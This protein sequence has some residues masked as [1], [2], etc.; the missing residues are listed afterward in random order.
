LTGQHYDKAVLAIDRIMKQYREVA[1]LQEQLAHLARLRDEG[2][3]YWRELSDTL[4]KDPT[5]LWNLASTYK[6]NRY[7]L[8]P[9]FVSQEKAREI[10]QR[11][12]GH[13]AI[14]RDPEKRKWIAEK[15]S[16]PGIPVWL[17]AQR[18]HQGWRWDNGKGFPFAAWAPG[19]PDNHE[20]KET[21]LTMISDGR[22]NDSEPGEELPFLVEWGP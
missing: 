11:C 17:G 4:E 14:I 12:G 18:T 3:P 5:S 21:G 22:W 6:H 2:I 7:L 15:F 13:L 9:Y 8:F 20:G 19:Q 16:L 10:A 1:A